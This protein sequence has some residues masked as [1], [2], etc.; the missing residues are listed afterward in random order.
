MKI[1]FD[2]TKFVGLLVAMVIGL[3]V[4][5]IL[6]AFLA[7]FWESKALNHL[8]HLFDLDQEKSIPTFYAVLA[9]LFSTGLLAVI[10]RD[11]QRKGDRLYYYWAGLAVI[12][13][14]LSID[15]S[16]SLHEK[17]IEPTKKLLNVSGIFYF[18][19]IIPY[20]LFLIVFLLVYMKFLLQLPRGTAQLF[21][22]AGFIYIFGAIGFESLSGLYYDRSSIYRILY[23]VEEFLEMIG[24]VIFIYGLLKYM[25]SR[26]IELN[27][28]IRS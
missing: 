7:G 5:Y 24:I 25:Q 12:F 9:L 15:E 10:S 3:T 17:L 26:R 22:I 8:F 28:T 1:Q 20:S 19:W 27:I 11:S 4:S 14:F 16:I 23:T 6:L 21:I 2:I 18:A 13:F